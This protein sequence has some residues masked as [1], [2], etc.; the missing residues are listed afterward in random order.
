MYGMDLSP[1]ANPSMLRRIIF[2]SIFTFNFCV[3]IHFSVYTGLQMRFKSNFAYLFLSV[4]A[5]YFSIRV[6]ITRI[7]LRYQQNKLVEIKNGLHRL[8]SLLEDDGRQQK[9]LIKLL[10]Y[11]LLSFLLPLSTIANIL[12]DLSQS[13]IA[14]Q[15][16]ETRL[17][18]SENNPT[19]G[20]IYRYM[21]SPFSFMWES[22]VAI[23]FVCLTAP[24]ALIFRSLCYKIKSLN[25]N[26]TLTYLEELS[27]TI[28]LHRQACLLF[29][30]TDK[31]FRSILVV[32]L[33]GQIGSC[34]TYGRLV[35]ERGISVVSV[36]LLTKYFGIMIVQIV[37]AG[38]TT[39]WLV[40]SLQEIQLAQSLMR[41]DHFIN[42]AISTKIDLYVT[43]VLLRQPSITVG[44][45]FSIKPTTAVKICAFILTYTVL[46]YKY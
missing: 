36:F 6:I 26:S 17:K 29:E 30:K 37:A 11:T 32:W 25:K 46:L 13:A 23:M 19:M 43:N 31:A 24:F 10:F 1:P 33:S 41:S 3:C 12:S 40:K 2:N 45:L 5:L 16:R 4:F 44:G 8:I 28:Q 35:S 22:F 14:K 20:L 15:T 34:L 9:F 42:L 7:M 21:S 27:E 39:H 38:F 18:V